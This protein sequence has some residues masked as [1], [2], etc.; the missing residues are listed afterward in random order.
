MKTAVYPGSFDPIT[1]GHLDVIQRA[2]R[3]VDRLIVAVVKNQSKK[4]LFTAE[5]RME[6]IRKSVREIP[7]VEVAHFD[8]LLVRFVADRKADVIIKGLRSNADFEYEL[9]M[10]SVNHSLQPDVETLF[11]MANPKYAYLSS[12]VVREVAGLGGDIRDF[13][14]DVVRDDILNKFR[15]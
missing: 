12:A 14:P 3:I 9:L 7:N 13:V 2:S 8:G 6:L 15:E 10:A 4:P 11:L 5:E 1:N